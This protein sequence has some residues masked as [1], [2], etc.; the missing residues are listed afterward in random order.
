MFD[1]RLRAPVQISRSCV[2]ILSASEQFQCLWPS[3]FL[4]QMKESLEKLSSILKFDENKN[5]DALN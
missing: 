3:Y 2:Q 1:D 5:K 4:F